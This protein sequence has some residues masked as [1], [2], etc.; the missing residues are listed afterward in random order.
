MPI[1][2]TILGATFVEY[3]LFAHLIFK[4]VKMHLKCFGCHFSIFRP[5]F[6]VQGVIFLKKFIITLRLFFY[7]ESKNV[8][9]LGGQKVF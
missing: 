9:C 3:N 6:K 5:R 1:K 2:S 8:T 7:E 4:G